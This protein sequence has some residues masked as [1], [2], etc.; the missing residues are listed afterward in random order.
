MAA[1][2]AVDLVGGRTA[3]DV[4]DNLVG[5][6]TA[7]Y[8]GPVTSWEI[9]LVLGGIPVAIMVLLALLTL[10]PNLRR[11][12]RYHPGEEWNHAPVW[13]TANPQQLPDSRTGH[14]QAVTRAGRGGCR[15]EW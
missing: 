9:I 12:P 7:R 15:G 14:H 2:P 8:R 5:D 6:R 11:P 13:W 3:G 10:G 4:P 1:A